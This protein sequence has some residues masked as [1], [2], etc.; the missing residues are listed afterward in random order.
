M[1][2]FLQRLGAQL[3]L[4]KDRL[5]S[6][7]IGTQRSE[8]EPLT[9]FSIVIIL[10]LD[11]FLF[12]LIADG[13]GEQ[14]KV[15]ET[16]Q[17]YASYQCRNTIESFQKLD[18]PEFQKTV[19]ENLYQTS[20]FTRSKVGYSDYSSSS[21]MFE[22]YA[23]PSKNLSLECVNIQ[24]LLSK[25]DSDLALQDLYRARFEIISNMKKNEEQTSSLRNNYDTKLL[26]KIANQNPDSTIDP[27]TAASTKNNLEMLATE[28]LKLEQRLTSNTAEIL[29]NEQVVEIT[30]LVAN[31]GEKVIAEYERRVFWYPVKVFW[32]QVIFLIPLLLIVIYWSNRSLMRGRPYQLL[33]A[34]HLLA[35][36]GLFVVLKL[37]EFVYEILPR[38]LIA[39]IID[40]LVSIQLVGIWY[41][42]VILLSVFVTLGIVYFIQQRVKIAAENRKLEVGAKRAEKWQCHSCGA[43]LITDAKH[44]IRC[45]AEQFVKCKSCGKQTPLAGE[46]CMHCGKENIQ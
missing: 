11:I 23:T 14:S 19:V 37:L 30:K 42:L 39:T 40:W 28:K 38:K 4:L 46:H 22:D 3:F 13:I 15:V 9:K 12:W 29:K 7:Q 20:T 45:G 41:Y 2:N 33:I 27:G 32:I 21:R 18:R 34:S 1:K 25:T 6:T 35:I 8:K 31:S 44:C 36:L 17:D 26:E 5:F 16:P 10:L 24:V 43:D